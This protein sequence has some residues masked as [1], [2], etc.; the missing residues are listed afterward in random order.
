LNYKLIA[1]DIDDTLLKSD[2]SVSCRTLDAI[3]RANEKGVLNCVATG[4]MYRATEKIR[5]YGLFGPAVCFGGA[6]IIDPKSG[7]VIFERCIENDLAQRI[8]QF[9]R[10]HDLY[11]M[12]YDDKTYYYE[13]PCEYSEFYERL[14]GFAGVQ[15][16]LEDLTLHTPKMLLIG[17]AQRIEQTM[18][19]AR[20]A[21]G[22]ELYISKSRATFM[23]LVDKTVSKGL[24]LEQIG[25]LYKIP[26]EQMIALGD[27]LIDVSMVDYAGL[28][29]AMENAVD[30]VKAVAD[31]ITAS[32]DEDGVALAIEKFVLKD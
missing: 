21:F 13:Y 16:N 31:Y 32:N 1:Y 30:E 2:L 20:Q 3:A 10:E 23:E 18:P 19:H 12:A 9:A 27:G 4:R 15:A 14:S 29:I 25:K 5:G 28:G 17:D 7:E 26:K 8:V 6:Q 22:D 11:V 24:A